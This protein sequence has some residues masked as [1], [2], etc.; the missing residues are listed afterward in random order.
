MSIF[1]AGLDCCV[2]SVS[3]SRRTTSLSRIPSFLLP[4][5]S[6]RRSRGNVSSNRRPPSTPHPTQKTAPKEYSTASIYNV[7]KSFISALVRAG[8]CQQHRRTTPGSRRVGLLAQAQCKTKIQPRQGERHFSTQARYKSQA[9][10]V[11]AY[12][13]T[14]EELDKLIDIYPDY[15]QQ[16]DKS[17]KVRQRPRRVLSSPAPDVA[18]STNDAATWKLIDRLAKQLQD[19][20]TPHEQLWQAYQDI[21]TPRALRLPKKILDRLFHHL[22]VVEYKSFESMS[23]YMSLVEDARAASI[24]LT[25]SQWTSAIAFAGRFL[26]QITSTEVDSAISLWRQMEQEAGVQATSITFNVLFDIATK[27]RKFVLAEMIMKEMQGRG[28]PLT[29]FLRTSLIEQYGYRG[30]GDGVR[31]AYKDLVEAGEI[32]DSVVITC[33]VKALLACGEAV[34]AE[35]V[36]ARA[37]ILHLEK[38]GVKLPP[39]SWRKR[40]EIG[41]MLDAATR[42]RSKTPGLR[43]QAEASAPLAPQLRTYKTLIFHYAIDAGDLDRI[44]ELVDEMG[45]WGIGIHGSLYMYIFNGFAKHGGVL[46]TAWSR[47]RLEQTWKS[48]V[49]GVKAEKGTWGGGIEEDA[50]EPAISTNPSSTTSIHPDHM[51]ISFASTIPAGLQTRKPDI[52]P[53]RAL[54][55]VVLRA[56]IKVAGPERTWDIWGEV[57]ATFSPTDEDSSYIEEQLEAMM[58]DRDQSGKSPEEE[59]RGHVESLQGMADD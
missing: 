33:V 16:V 2:S 29:R 17:E 41:R 39:K 21:P 1:L 14:K 23:R 40:R 36:F 15:S 26:K 4:L 32:V 45:H 27:A 10:A 25:A 49:R 11:E 19:I 12:Q 50:L 58:P 9:H 56:F 30:D 42:S 18:A 48:F 13:P 44:T 46:Y 28:L 37:K 31:K 57:Q 38:T 8:E 6:S 55:L 24:A 22:S 20:E 7:Q 5:E 43:E 59:I 34:A 52:Y 51:E 3:R 54:T 53:T 35:Q 47:R